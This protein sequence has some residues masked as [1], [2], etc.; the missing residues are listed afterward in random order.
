M[1]HYPSGV[2]R[3]LGRATR[4]IPERLLARLLPGRY[5]FDPTD[6]PTATVPDAACRLYIGPVNWA[7]QGWQWARAV[8]RNL[9]GVGAVSMSYRVAGEFTFPVDLSV[10]VTGFVFS[11]GW[12]RRQLA[13]VRDRFTHVIVEAERPLFGRVFDQSAQ[14]QVAILGR[15]GVRVAMLCH[16]SDIRLPSRHAA[17]NP[18]SPFHDRLWDLTPVLEKQARA[19]RAVLDR[20]GLPVFVSTPDL[21]LDVPTA[22]WLPVVVDADRWSTDAPPLSGGR[23][24][25]AHAPSKAIVKGSDLI[26]PIMRKLDAEGLIEYRRIEHVPSGEMPGVYRSADIVLDQFRI[27]SYGVAACEALAAG[28]VVIAHVG[29]QVREHVRRATE[30]DLPILQATPETL[31]PLI[32]DI[33]RKPAPYR[34]RAADG[35]DF[36]RAVHDGR[37]SAEVLR[38][39]L[40]GEPTA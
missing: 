30:R 2:T 25:V 24:I 17:A 7:G 31:E 22:T 28:R 14:D 4:L 13:V 15:H 1:S 23:P 20:L 5:A 34:D 21:L 6:L 38:P 35:P 16:G 3:M 26:D 40:L 33:V 27:G 8:E 12:Q 18:L 19:N 32:R 9:E 39:F 10:P 36:V 29:D 11:S 37:R